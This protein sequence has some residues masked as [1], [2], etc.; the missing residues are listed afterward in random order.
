[1]KMFYLLVLSGLLLAIF[2]LLTAQADR[3]FVLIEQSANTSMLTCSYYIDITNDIEKN[4]TYS[5]KIMIN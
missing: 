4:K 2:Q 5:G 3:Q 1:M